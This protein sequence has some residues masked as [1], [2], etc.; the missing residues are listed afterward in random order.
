MQEALAQTPMKIFRFPTLVF[1]IAVLLGCLIGF[2]YV[3]LS[4]WILLYALLF[5][6]PLLVL[7][8]IEFLKLDF[9]NRHGFAVGILSELAIFLPIIALGAIGFA[10]ESASFYFV[11]FGP[12]FATVPLFSLALG[13]KGIARGSLLTLVFMLLTALASGIVFLAFALSTASPQ[14]KS[15]VMDYIKCQ[16]FNSSEDCW[17]SEQMESY[18]YE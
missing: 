17:T 8:G 13:N 14:D 4:T 2:L 15:M 5:I 3:G 6:A 12:W 9:V 10:S 7:T 16:W 18:L 1:T 11:S